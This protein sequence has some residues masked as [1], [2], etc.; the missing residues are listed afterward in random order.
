[1]QFLPQ[2]TWKKLLVIFAYSAIAVIII[3]FLFKYLLKYTL[4]FV[5]SFLIALYTRPLYHCFQRRGLNKKLSA[6]IISAGIYLGLG[7]GALFILRRVFYQV[8][9]MVKRVVE[10]PDIILKPFT[11]A[12]NAIESKFPRIAEIIEKTNILSTLTEKAGGLAIELGEKIALLATKLPDILLFI[13]VTVLSTYYFICSF[14]DIINFMKTKLPLALSCFMLA[15][16]RHFLSCSKKYVLCMLIMLTL[17]FF[18]L[19]LGFYV[20]KI[21]YALSLS[22]II[23]LIDMLPVLGVGTV[24]IPWAIISAAG[25]N[26]KRAAGLAL[27]YLAITVIRQIIEPKI[28]GKGMG[29]SPLLTLFAMYVGYVSLGIFGLIIAPLIAGVITSLLKEAF[30]LTKE[31]SC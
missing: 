10:E 4:P 23:A 30:M 11:S 3:Y 8:S 26:L 20:L 21:P 15:G 12:Y 2:K 17:T 1:M 24:L 29:T 18:E 22:L 6:L 19:L 9:D 14:D 27:L 13:F 31:N 5:I 25:G 16:K 7:S 28:M